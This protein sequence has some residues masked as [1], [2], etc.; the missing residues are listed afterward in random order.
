MV[1]IM[2]SIE[3]LAKEALTQPSDSGWDY[4]LR[5][6]GLWQS[7]GMSSWSVTRD[8]DL[9]EQ[10][11]WVAIQK[12]LNEEFG[13]ERKLP[14]PISGE[15]DLFRD[16][17]IVRSS[18]WAVGW[19]EQI[20]V[21]ILIDKEGEIEED[22]IT[23]IFKRCIELKKDTIVDYPL[24]DD[25]IYS[26]LESE[27]IINNIKMEIPGW[28]DNSDP[29]EIYTWLRENEFYPG[30]DDNTWYSEGEV[31]IACL[32]LGFIDEDCDQEELDDWLI[33]Y[34][35]DKEKGNYHYEY[36]VWEYLKEFRQWCDAVNQG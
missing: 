4:S 35:R 29:D 1:S 20:M 3:D 12:I 28:V 32:A 19:V 2:D 25:S 11:N 33:K 24:L 21:R 18:H 7:W 10:A 5:D 14:D 8:S 30:G 16:W 22:N 15:Q 36:N 6:M 9:Y 17:M 34:S 23:D 31:G 26:E 13:P 27:Q